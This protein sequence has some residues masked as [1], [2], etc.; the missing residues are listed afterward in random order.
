L[1][2]VLYEMDRKDEA[3]QLIKDSALALDEEIAKIRAENPGVSE[4]AIPSSQQDGEEAANKQPE[5]PA[6]L[7]KAAKSS[8]ARTHME[9]GRLNLKME[10]YDDAITEFNTALDIVNAVFGE[11]SAESGA[12]ISQLANTYKAAKR[13][14]DAAATFKRL[15]DISLASGGL[16]QQSVVA[17]ARELSALYDELEQPDQCVHFA[18]QALTGLQLLLG[19]EVHPMMEQFFQALIKA[20]EKAGDTVGAE[21]VKRRFVKGIAHLQK[22]MMA[23]QRAGGRGRNGPGVSPN[24]PG[25][26][27]G[28]R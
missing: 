9:L 28:R 24:K 17:I 23:M 12:P 2:D 26:K 21:A 3:R 27:A 11:G 10:L 6:E 13:P 18:E 16:A 22:Q 8:L 25:K 14:A 4:A 20:K 1:V 5:T 15:Y 7:L 19:V